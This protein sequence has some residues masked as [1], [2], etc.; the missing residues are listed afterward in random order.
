MRAV[1]R[2]ERGERE[3]VG[4]RAGRDPERLD[5]ALEQLGKGRIQPLAP[6]VAVIGGVEPVRLARCAASASGQAAAALS[7]KK[8][9]IGAMIGGFR[10]PSTPICSAEARG[11]LSSRLP[12]FSPLGLCVSAKT[13]WDEVMGVE[14]FPN[15]PAGSK[16]SAKRA[17]VLLAAKLQT[18]VRRGR[19]APARPVAQGRAGRVRAGPERR[20]RGRLRARRDRGPRPRRLGRGQPRRPRIRSYDRRA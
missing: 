20:Q 11:F 5:L 8:R 18:A 4:G 6:G 19:G 3:R 10:A 17:R 16:R 14:N 1:R 12:Q 15:A 13:S 7:E 9:M 2:A